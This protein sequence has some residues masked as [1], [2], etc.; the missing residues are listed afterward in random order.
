MSH[1]VKTALGLVACLLTAGTALGAAFMPGTPSTTCANSGFGNTLAINASAAGDSFTVTGTLTLNMMPGGPPCV[2]QWVVDSPFVEV[3]GN[4]TNTSSF[5]GTLTTQTAGWTVGFTERT[6]HVDE[7][8]VGVAV[9]QDGPHLYG[10]PG[11]YHFGA[12]PVNG[13]PFA[14]GPGADTLR[15]TFTIDLQPSAGVISFEFPV[16]SSTE[17]PEPAAGLPL[18]GIFGL[19]GYS[20]RRRIRRRT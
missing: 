8:G 17:V 7:L 18:T 5:S 9:A 15:Q 19:L 12:G 10:P 2:I 20:W 3:A 6:E 16:L 11:A 13:V 1:L 14:D 4:Y